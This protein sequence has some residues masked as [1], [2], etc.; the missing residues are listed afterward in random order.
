MPTNMPTFPENL[1]KIDPVQSEI[2]SLQGDC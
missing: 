2:I 1:V